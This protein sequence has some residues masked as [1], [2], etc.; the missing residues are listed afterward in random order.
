MSNVLVVAEH[1]GGAL[2]KTTLASIT[3]ARQAAQK[4]GGQVHVLV[5][6]ASIGG[7][8][9]EVKKYG[10]AVVWVAESPAL[11]NFTAEAYAHAA[12]KAAEASGATVVCASA[13]TMG[14]DFLPRVAARLDAGMASD[15]AAIEDVGGKLAFK[16]PMWAGNLNQWVEITTAKK[17]VSVRPT[18]FEA[19]AE[20]APSGEVKSLDVGI[21]PGSLKTKFVSFDEAKSDRPDL[22]EARVVV[23]GGRGC[24]GPEGYKETVEVLADALGAAVG[25]TRAIVDAGW[26]PNDWQVGQTGKVVAPDLYIAVGLSGAIQHIAG[27]AGSKTIVA[28]NKDADAPIFKIADYGLVADLFQAIPEFIGEYKRVTS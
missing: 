27:M 15:V 3:F 17:V 11:A 2:R 8:A 12:A 14:R 24:K 13:T 21:D 4:T 23:S 18:E 9:D 19:P 10:P 7:V 28:I 6:G 5:C 16:R 26:V 22:T 20:G 1:K 25:A